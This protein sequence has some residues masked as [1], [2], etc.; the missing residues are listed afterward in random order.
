M[1]VWANA[2]YE[3]KSC[4]VRGGEVVVGMG[5][6]GGIIYWYDRREGGRQ[7]SRKEE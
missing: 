3:R 2:S 4:S 6:G 5:R 7:M 1:R